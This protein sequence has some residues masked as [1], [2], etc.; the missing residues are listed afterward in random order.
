[1]EAL[2]EESRNCA[3]DEWRGFV[4][5]Y[6]WEMSVNI[7]AVTVIKLNLAPGRDI[8]ILNYGGTEWRVVTRCDVRKINQDLEIA[9]YIVYWIFSL[10][11]RRSDTFMFTLRNAGNAL[12][13]NRWCPR[14]ELEKRKQ[15]VAVY[16][17]WSMFNDAA[18]AVK[19]D[20]LIFRCDGDC[21]HVT[22]LAYRTL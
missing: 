13:V 2:N 3:W 12:F 14:S 20:S 18:S 21:L 19:F 16:S 15:R 6:R 10:F 17:V 5:I 8:F 11:L 1:M 9:C 22:Y 7:A 4:T